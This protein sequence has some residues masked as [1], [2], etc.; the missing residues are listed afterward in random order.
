M[1]PVIE[2]Q[3]RIAF[4]YVRPEAREDAVEEVAA[5]ALVAFVRLIEL[6]KADVAY[7]TPLAK[8][9]IRQVKDGRRVGTKLNVR[10][11]SST[12]CQQRTGAI[13][14]RLDRFDRDEGQW[15]EILVEDRR[16][17]PA[18][19]AAARIDIAEWFGLLPDRDQKIAAALAVGTSTGD[20][21][22]NFRLS[23]A[24]ISQKRCELRASWREFQGEDQAA[25]AAVA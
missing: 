3:A 24:R 11:I 5:N 8:Y 18:E 13:L 15:L 12:Y 20:V 1:L 17:G 16:A 10:D 19:T 9:G 22:K 25:E 14:E 6:G 7:P 2:R 23:P 4:K 21:A